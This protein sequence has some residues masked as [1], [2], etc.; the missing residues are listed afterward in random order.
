M[1]TISIFFFEIVFNVPKIQIVT[2]KK[3]AQVEKFWL[4]VNYLKINYKLT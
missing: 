3:T 4:R 1:Q 2:K